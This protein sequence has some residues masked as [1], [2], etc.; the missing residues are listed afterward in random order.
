MLRTTS[1]STQQGN[2][3]MAYV[4]H[5]FHFW[6]QLCPGSSRNPTH[7]DSFYYNQVRDGPLRSRK[8]TT[9][10][11]VLFAQESWHKELLFHVISVWQGI[12]VNK[13]FT[14]YREYQVKWSIKYRT[15]GLRSGLFATRTWPIYTAEIC[16][17]MWLHLELDF[18]MMISVMYHKHPLMSAWYHNRLVIETSDN[19]AFQKSVLNV[20][21]SQ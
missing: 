7:Y 15:Q 11:F 5:S 6:C 10:T 4:S 12:H 21:F 16:L 17:P 9:G 18:W 2:I 1:S 20:H 19:M 8:V 14:I 3:M 13:K